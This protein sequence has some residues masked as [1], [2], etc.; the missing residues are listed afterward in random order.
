MG[1]MDRGVMEDGVMETIRRH[2]DPM[3]ADGLTI[4]TAED[5]RH[6]VAPD[7]GVPVA[8]G[9]PRAS[10]EST[11]K[12]KAGTGDKERSGGMLPVVAG[13]GLQSESDGGAMRADGA[14]WLLSLWGAASTARYLS[15]QLTTGK[16]LDV[17]TTPPLGPWEPMWGST[18]GGY[19]RLR[20]GVSTRLSH[21]LV[22]GRACDATRLGAGERTFVVTLR[23]DRSDQT[24]EEV[25]TAFLI[26]L[27]D[28]PVDPAWAGWLWRRARAKG[29]ARPLM[30]WGPV[31]REAWE[32]DVPMTLRADISAARAGDSPYGDLPIP[33]GVQAA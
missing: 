4:D 2:A 18:E 6:A 10:T 5:A 25:Y 26:A 1:G 23:R 31:L 22:L 30:V 29:E 9:T 17:Q 16:R 7:D 28:E 3:S 33:V 21:T 15:A 14:L 24:A 19:K 27:L 32:C 11:K 20:R 8:E 13:D 12:G